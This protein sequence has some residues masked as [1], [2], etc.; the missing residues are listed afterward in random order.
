MF[1]L[2][3]LS[4]R[5]QTND[6]VIMMW[7]VS[8]AYTGVPEPYAV[9]I[10]PSLSLCLS[11]LYDHFPRFNWYGFFWFLFLFFAYTGLILTIFKAIKPELRIIF[12]TLIFVISIHFCLFPQFTLVA[13]WCMISALLLLFS[14]GGSRK[15]TGLQ[16]FGFVLLVI[17]LLVRIESCILVF[18][19]WIVFQVFSNGMRTLSKNLP[20]YALIILF[21]GLAFGSKLIYEKKNVDKEFLAFNKARSSVIDHPGF[22]HLSRNKGIEKGTDWK[23]FSRWFMDD[24]DLSVEELEAKKDELDQLIFSKN[25]F[26]NSILRLWIIGKTELFKVFISSVIILLFL[27]MRKN[28]KLSSGAVL[29]ILFFL[30]MNHFFLLQG[31][32]QVLFALVFLFPMLMPGSRFK[33][34]LPTKWIGFVLLGLLCLH[35]INTRMEAKERHLMNQ[36][37]FNLLSENNGEDPVFTEGYMEYHFEHVYHKDSLAPVISFGWIS[38]SEFQSKALRIRNISSMRNL[39][40]FHLFQAKSKEPPIFPD[41]VSFLNGKLYLQK[42]EKGQYFNFYEYSKVQ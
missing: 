1:I 16:L 35:F 41:Y 3:F 36:E 37:F 22:Y 2:W 34:N 17:G 6:D 14:E 20:R 5:F 31:R 10:H 29:W 12:C 25:S 42:I 30:L 24:L 15:D 32:V 40:S 19:G 18:I 4:W 23:Y 21:I 38:N 8:G 27:V 26:K 13:G 9:F 11:V 33:W 39:D 28:W 7:L